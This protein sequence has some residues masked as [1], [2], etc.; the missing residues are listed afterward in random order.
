M[1]S[2]CCHVL[3]LSLNLTFSYVLFLLYTVSYGRCFVCLT[4]SPH[5]VGYGHLWYYFS[6]TLCLFYSWHIG[7]WEPCSTSCGE[8]VQVR[9]VFC[10]QRV[11]EDL[12]T[13]VNSKLCPDEK[14]PAV[15]ACN[16]EVE[17]PQWEVEQWSKVSSY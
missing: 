9:T 6:I 14:P 17:C 11:D 16:K 4:L 8:G 1:L 5:I 3:I 10:Q 13:I 12:H 7:T 2:S 15:Q